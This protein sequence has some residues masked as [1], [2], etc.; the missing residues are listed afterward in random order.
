M[1]SRTFGVYRWLPICSKTV[2]KKVWLKL[3][4]QHLL[5]IIINQLTLDINDASRDKIKWQDDNGI[6]V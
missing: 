1:N 2:N 4:A 6:K 3:G 5:H